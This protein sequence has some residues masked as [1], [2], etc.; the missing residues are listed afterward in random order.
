MADAYNAAPLPHLR[1]SDHLS[2]LLPKHSPLI[3]HVKPTVRTDR[4]WPEGADSAP[5]P[6]FE[7]TDWNMFATLDHPV[8]DID[9]YASSSFGLYQLQH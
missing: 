8:T 6:H 3:R 4:V 1:Q 9:L 2:Q 7:N 5:P